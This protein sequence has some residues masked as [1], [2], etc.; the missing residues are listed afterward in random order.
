MVEKIGDSTDQAPFTT[1]VTLSHAVAAAPAIP[2]HAALNAPTAVPATVETRPMSGAN[3]REA[4]NRTA[5]VNAVRPSSA[6]SFQA[7]RSKPPAAT[8][9]RRRSNV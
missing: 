2:D 8:A 4:A 9:A 3:T 6:S 5:T 1:D 7:A